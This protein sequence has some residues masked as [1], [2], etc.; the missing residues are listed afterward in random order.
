M[1][2][3]FFSQGNAKVSEIFLCTPKKSVKSDEA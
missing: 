2:S 1:K 3:I